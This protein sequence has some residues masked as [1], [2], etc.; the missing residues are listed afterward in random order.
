MSG[1]PANVARRRRARATRRAGG[2]RARRARRRPGRGGAWGGRRRP[3]SGG[4]AGSGPRGGPVGAR[5]S[6]RS[7][8]T[9]SA[10]GVRGGRARRQGGRP[11]P[12]GSGRRRGPGPGG[13]PRA[14]RPG[15]PLDLGEI[16]L[17]V[18]V[19]RVGQAMGERPVVGQQEQPLAVAVE[20]ADRVD[21]GDRHEV[22][23]RRPPALVGELGEDVEGLEEFIV[24]EGRRGRPRLPPRVDLPGGESSCLVIS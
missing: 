12:G 2:H 10:R 21:P 17:G 19:A 16:G 5:P 8:G 15:N 18:L 23:E 20:P 7:C 13:G 1:A 6:G 9:G 11:R 14:P 22:L 24:A 3:S 4:P